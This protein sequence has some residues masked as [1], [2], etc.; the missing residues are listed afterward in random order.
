MPFILGI[1]EISAETWRMETPRWP[2]LL[3]TWGPANCKTPV[4][5]IEGLDYNLTMAYY[6]IDANMYT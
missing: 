6:S 1:R 3:S 2:T 4:V 5:A